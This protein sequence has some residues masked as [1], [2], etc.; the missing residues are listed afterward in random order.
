V[1]ELKTKVTEASVA[2][3]VESIADEVKREDSRILV[4]MM[5]EATS[6]EPKMWGSSIIGFGAYHYV[7]ESGREGDWFVLGFSPRKQ[8]LTLY[9]LGGWPQHARLLAQLGKHSLGKGCRYIRRLADVNLTILRRLIGEALT[10][11]AELSKELA[12]KPAEPKR[13]RTLK[14]RTQ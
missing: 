8:A 11:A 4:Q 9:L 5:Q 3:F 13:V 10:R 12:A 7:Y 14:G 6:A 1:A 2:Q